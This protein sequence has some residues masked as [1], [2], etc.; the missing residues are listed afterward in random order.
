MTFVVPNIQQ[1]ESLS[2]FQ[3]LR[4]KTPTFWESL[5]AQSRADSV[6]TQIYRAFHKQT[7]W[8]IAGPV[9][10]HWNKVLVHAVH[11]TFKSHCNEILRGRGWDGGIDCW[12]IG[13]RIDG[14]VPKVIVLCIDLS[15][16]KRFMR[17]IIKDECWQ[18]SGFGMVGRR[19][20]LKYV[21]GLVTG[22]NQTPSS[23]VSTS[24]M[25]SPIGRD[26][27]ATEDDI[28]PSPTTST[29]QDSTT[30]SNRKRLHPN[31]PEPT[32]FSGLEVLIRSRSGQH[33]DDTRTTTVGGLVLLED[34]YYCLCAAHPF[35]ADSGASAVTTKG[36]LEEY[37]EREDD[38]LSWQDV[39]EDFEALNDE[40]SDGSDGS[41][42]SI[43]MPIDST[44]NTF[45]I[46][47]EFV[48]TADV[49]LRSSTGD[50]KSSIEFSQPLA[51]FTKASGENRPNAAL[52]KDWALL[53]PKVEPK[54]MIN[55]VQFQGRTLRTTRLGRLSVN[56]RPLLLRSKYGYPRQVEC[57]SGV[58]LIPSLAQGILD[59][60][61]IINE[62]IG[63]LSAP[64]NNDYTD[65]CPKI[66]EKAG[67]GSSTPIPG[68]S[69][70]SF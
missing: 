31:S 35:I 6:N 9:L 70:A 44:A 40:S 16:V 20:C 68:I 1:P 2:V 3:L 63:M 59:S 32:D 13:D 55:Q 48:E 50:S 64:T 43:P 56:T 67:H 39:E 58:S 18:T 69:L 66:L 30:Q 38:L 7:A 29:A 19:G 4:P 42:K 14:A 10:E 37:D 8:D 52:E 5:C 11:A 21:G 26:V 65:M 24:L 45:R 23:A 51:S 60:A 36:I 57:S 25:A 53:T 49:F 54:Y 22:S 12:M 46:E 33:K 61:H 47:N 34:T 15:T 41:T 17:K 28:M 27:N 62:R